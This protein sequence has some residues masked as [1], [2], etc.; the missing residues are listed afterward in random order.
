MEILNSKL[1]CPGLLNVLKRERLVRV[2]ES[3]VHKKL[4]TV[5]AGAGYG[6]STLVVD[7]LSRID[8]DFVWYRLDEQDMDFPVFMTYLKAGIQ[9]KFTETGYEAGQEP[10]VKSSPLRFLKSG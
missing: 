6:K 3:I 10:A 7:A 8:I 4:I 2:F 5:I 1:Q 9:A